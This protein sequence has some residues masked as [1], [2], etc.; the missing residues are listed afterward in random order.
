MKFFDKLFPD[1]SEEKEN[2]T[3]TLFKQAF[4]KGT[5]FSNSKV[6]HIVSF[7]YSDANM[8]LFE[9][10]W[11]KKDFYKI[12]GQLKYN[13]QAN[14]VEIYY[15]IAPNGK[16]EVYMIADPF[17]LLEKEYIIRKYEEILDEK[18]MMLSTVEQIN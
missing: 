1:G 3:F 8:E 7:E 18:I 9:S 2:A 14:N 13:A 12:L 11:D 16:G 15:V 17:E 4:P 10:N 6:Y 5:D